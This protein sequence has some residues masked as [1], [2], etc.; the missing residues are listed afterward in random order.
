[1]KGYAYLFSFL[2][3]TVS[4]K[5]TV[6]KDKLEA[7]EVQP[8]DMDVNK[9]A[10][11]AKRQYND[12]YIFGADEIPNSGSSDNSVNNNDNSAEN[13]AEDQNPNQPQNPPQQNIDAG[14]APA[15]MY[16]IIGVGVG[17]PKAKAKKKAKVKKKGKK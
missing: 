10:M 17:K 3:A 6:V 5:G 15:Q 4:V 14:A 12:N 13:P 8:V 16:P 11:N 1:M 9:P 2:I 7:R